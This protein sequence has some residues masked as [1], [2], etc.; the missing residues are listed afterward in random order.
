MYIP[1]VNSF[2]LILI[3]GGV[4]VGML[5]FTWLMAHRRQHIWQHFARQHGLDFQ[6]APTGPRVRGQIGGRDLVLECARRSS[7]TGELGAEEVKLIRQ[8]HGPLPPRLCIA[9]APLIESAEKQ[10]HVTI[11]TG[12]EVFD[13]KVHATSAD[14]AALKEY[15]TAPRRAAM[16]QVLDMGDPGQS[17]VENGSVCVVEREIFSSTQHLEKRLAELE[18]VIPVLDAEKSRESIP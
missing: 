5:L 12:D 9:S 6:L 11:P 10:S 3:V 14:P 4:V 8:I 18:H 7:D 1:D 15:L 17:S 16:L 2:Q 13:A